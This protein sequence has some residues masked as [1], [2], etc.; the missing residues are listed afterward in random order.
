MKSI[1]RTISR[2]A[3]GVQLSDLLHTHDSEG[4][5]LDNITIF[6]SNFSLLCFLNLWTKVNYLHPI[7]N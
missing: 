7:V 3:V 2:A 1:L 5:E 6:K 4:R